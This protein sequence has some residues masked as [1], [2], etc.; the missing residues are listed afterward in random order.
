MLSGI[1]SSSACHKAKVRL[2]A[3]QHDIRHVVLRDLNALSRRLDLQP[4][5]ALSAL[6]GV[7]VL[8]AVGTQKSGS[9]DPAKVKSKPSPCWETE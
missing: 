3:G 2:F 1:V 4:V 9:V 8:V 5:A 7:H 6:A